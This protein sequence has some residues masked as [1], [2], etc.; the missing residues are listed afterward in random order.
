MAQER[1]EVD[2]VYVYLQEEV[3]NA[4]EPVAARSYDKP[5]Q[6]NDTVE[7]ERVVADDVLSE[8]SLPFAEKK[9]EVVVEI[10]DEDQ[11]LCGIITAVG[12]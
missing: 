7:N 6:R 3:I 11:P 9:K 1:S 4:S 8:S 5:P 2:L 10:A 12:L